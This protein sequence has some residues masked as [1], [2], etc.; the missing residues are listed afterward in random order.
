MIVNRLMELLEACDFE[1]QV[2]VAVS[3]GSVGGTQ[4]GFELLGLA[5]DPQGTVW[6]LT[7]AAANGTDASLWSSQCRVHP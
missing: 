2:K 7:G 4:A 3:V 6:L 5:R 1:A